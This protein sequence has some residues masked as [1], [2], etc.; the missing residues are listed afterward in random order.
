MPEVATDKMSPSP[1]RDKHQLVY[2]IC[3]WLGIGMLL[4]WNFFSQVNGYWMYKFRNIPNDTIQSE[5][6][7]FWGSNLALVSMAPNFTFL[8]INA[9]IGHKLRYILCHVYY[10]HPPIKFFKIAAYPQ[11]STVASASTS[12][13]SSPP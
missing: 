11:E 6:Q 9:L 5:K 4:P 13:S 1:P 12:S 3:C 10:L 8:F 2:I 7:K